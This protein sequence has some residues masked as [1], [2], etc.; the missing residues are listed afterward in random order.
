M[1][2]YDVVEMWRDGEVRTCGIIGNIKRK[3]WIKDNDLVLVASWDFLSDTANA[4]WR[5]I[6]ANADRI[7]LDGYPDDRLRQMSNGVISS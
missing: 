3:M 4:V 5:Y 2:R 6:A 1:P 7:E